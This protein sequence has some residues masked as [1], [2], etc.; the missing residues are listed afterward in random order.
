[1]EQTAAPPAETILEA[2]PAIEVRPQ[3]QAGRTIRSSPLVRRLAKEHGIDLASVQGTGLGGRISKQD[4]LNFLS[5]SQ[6]S[7]AAAAGPGV[8]DYPRTAAAAPPAPTALPPAGSA[9]RTVVFNGP[10][11]SVPMTAMRRQIAE[12]MLASKRTSAHV[13]TFFEVEMTRIV[14]TQAR[15]GA[16]F[17]RRN[18]M[19]LTYTPFFARAAVEALKQ[20]PIMNSSLDGGNVVYKRDINI[21]V[22]VALETGLIV[23]VIKHA[24][25]KNFLGVARALR[26]LADRARSKRLGVEDV[27][28]GTFTI[29]NPGIFGSVMGAPIIN[30]PQVAILG[31]GVIEKRPVVRNDAIA[32]RTM[33]YL[34][35]SFD[36][37]VLDGAIADQFMAKVK[38][39]LENWE[40]AV[41]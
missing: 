12:H 10:T 27:Q 36:H 14:E 30:Q 32:I 2:Q 7:R 19:K 18:G 1:S 15:Y 22:A 16:E 34:S 17:E 25:E 3:A 11:Q 4:V 33:V 28:D 40:E 24:G 31:V 39:V 35:L 23:P 5:S 6:A 26:D 38:S 21:G 13:H 8:P 41:L 20:F 29:T 37:R 9:A